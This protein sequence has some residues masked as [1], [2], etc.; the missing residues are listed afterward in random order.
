MNLYWK[1]SNFKGEEEEEPNQQDAHI[2]REEKKKHS[3]RTQAG[4]MD[5]KGLTSSPFLVTSVC[6]ASIA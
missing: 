6:E 5:E 2:G 3:H 1:R 4:G